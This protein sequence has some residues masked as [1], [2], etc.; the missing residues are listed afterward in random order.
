MQEIKILQST[1]TER[2]EAE[3]N[4]Y[5]KMGFSILKISLDNKDVYGKSR[6]TTSIFL[7]K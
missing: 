4:E 5:L 7:I 2:I 1:D 6:L 3:A